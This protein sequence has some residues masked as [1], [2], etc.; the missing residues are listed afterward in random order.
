MITKQYVT[1]ANPEFI[2]ANRMKTRDKHQSA[3]LEEPIPRV[4]VQGKSQTGNFG[5]GRKWV[6]GNRKRE[7]K[8]MGKGEGG[9]QREHSSC[10]GRLYIVLSCHA[11]VRIFEVQHEFHLC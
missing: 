7:T 1:K 10:T 5:G 6:R 11:A 9:I 3:T 2:S 4:E 8:K